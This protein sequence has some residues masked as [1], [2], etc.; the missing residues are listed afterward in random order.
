MLKTEFW[1]RAAGSLPASVRARHVGDI[2][3]A[4][5]I[6][7]LVEGIVDAWSQLRT[8]YARA[9]EPRVR[10]QARHQH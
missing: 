9:G 2:A 3:R 6:D 8:F 10:H 5:R 4:E 7:I 1:K